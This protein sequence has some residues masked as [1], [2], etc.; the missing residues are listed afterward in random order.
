MDFDSLV[1]QMDNI[2]VST[3]QK[4]D[5]DAGTLQLI[6]HPTNGDPDIPVSCVVKNPAMEEDYVP[7]S[8]TGTAML[9]L[10]IPASAGVMAVRGDTASYNGVVYNVVQSDGDRCGGL[11]IRLRALS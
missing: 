3:F 10:F 9:M 1:G 8:L 6:L 5:P 7:G 11:H 2:V 4:V